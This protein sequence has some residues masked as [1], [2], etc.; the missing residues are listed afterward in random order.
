M[1]NNL[2]GTCES[3][4]NGVKKAIESKPRGGSIMRGARLDTTQQVNRLLKRTIN[5][6]VAGEITSEKAKTIGYLS[7]ILLKGLELEEAKAKVI[8]NE[9]EWEFLKIPGQ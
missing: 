5:Q 9:K 7:T 2:N 1:N 3:G 4:I 6:L 8:A